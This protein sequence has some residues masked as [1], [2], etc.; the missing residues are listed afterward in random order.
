MKILL[1]NLDLTEN[2][3]LGGNIDYNK[4]RPAIVN[5]QEMYIR[6]LLGKELYEKIRDDFNVDSPTKGFSGLYITLY[7]D[8][9]KYLIVHSSCELYLAYAPYTVSNIGITKHSTDQSETVN[10]EEVDFLIESSR[11][12]FKIYE[13]E[14][15][16]WLKNNNIPEYT[17]S[18]KRKT[19][20]VGGWKIK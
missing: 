3:L 8:F 12:M 10:K 4:Y 20:K 5:A 6:P 19:N 9:I 15:L 7:E 14:M 17:V 2:T 16:D 13:R 1:D 18:C 11:K